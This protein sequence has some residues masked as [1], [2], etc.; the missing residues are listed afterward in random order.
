[1]N[2][3]IMVFLLASAV[4]VSCE[5]NTGDFTLYDDNKTN[6]WIVCQS[7]KIEAGRYYF[8]EASDPF[9]KSLDHVVVGRFVFIYVTNVSESTNR[10]MTYSIGELDNTFELKC[11]NKISILP[12][13]RITFKKADYLFKTI[14]SE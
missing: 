13:Y 3:L 6:E 10:K 1:M 9:N 11:G 8:S 12:G 5:K 4:L 2:K 7:D 14:E